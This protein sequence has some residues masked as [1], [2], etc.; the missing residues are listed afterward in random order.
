MADADDDQI[1]ALDDLNGEPIGP[2]GEKSDIIILKSKPATLRDKV[3][4]SR[5]PY[6]DKNWKHL[7][8]DSAYVDLIWDTFPLY[9]R[10]AAA[11]RFLQKKYE[12]TYPNF[13]PPVPDSEFW[14]DSREKMKSRKSKVERE[15]SW[16]ALW[17]GCSGNCFFS[18]F[19]YISENF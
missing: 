6:S 10:D 12:L 1:S 13:D 8:S 14:F 16:E 2:D 17:L 4:S 18:L 11:K 15:D 3:K 19:T 7:I 5:Q 9:L